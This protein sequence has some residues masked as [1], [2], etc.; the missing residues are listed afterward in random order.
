MRILLVGTSTNEKH[1][2]R[3]NLAGFNHG[4]SRAFRELGHRVDSLSHQEAKEKARGHY[5]F[6]LLRD[7]V[8]IGSTAVIHLRRMCDRFAM[9]THAEYI[10]GRSIDKPF[11]NA[12]AKAGA[13]P[14]HIFLDQQLGWKVYEEQG[15][16]VPMT[17]LGFGANLET[18]VA[19]EKDIDVLWV[20]HGYAERQQRVENL[21][22]PLIDILGD[23]YNVRIHGRNQVHGSLS[24]P[25]MFNAMSR[26][27]IVIH[28]CHMAHWKGGYG[29]RTIW[30]A[31][32]S[33]AYVVHDSFA[34]DKESF[35]Y[36]VSFVP[37]DQVTDEVLRILEEV[38]PEDLEDMTEA[39]YEWVREGHMITHVAKKML[40]IVGVR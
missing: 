33:R 13:L 15:I 18:H 1:K 6:F 23:E 3:G 30:D 36:G 12:L 14:Q 17:W 7:T 22:Y 9:F 29:G 34:T 28:L 24:I 32:A 25:E 39:G 40:D 26:A 8:P 27:R 20:G 37:V 10:Q 31:L 2:A 11:F 5:D 21:V 38:D 4:Y 35:P 19:D 16:K